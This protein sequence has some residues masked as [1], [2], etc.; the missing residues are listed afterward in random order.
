MKVRASASVS[1]KS[2]YSRGPSSSGSGHL[3]GKGLGVKDVIN[4]EPVNAAAHG[5][6]NYNI[7]GRL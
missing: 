7:T 1:S 3:A 4:S 2:M 6:D 5:N